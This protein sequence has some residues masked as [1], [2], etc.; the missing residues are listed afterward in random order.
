MNTLAIMCLSA[1]EDSLEQASIG[2]GAEYT[3]FFNSKLEKYGV[4]SPQELSEKDRKRFFSEVELEWDIENPLTDDGDEEDNVVLSS[5]IRYN[6]GQ[7]VLVNKG[8]D[9]ENPE[10]HTGAITKA[11]RSKYVV[12]LDSGDIVSYS[13]DDTGTGILGLVNPNEVHRMAV[14]NYK[15]ASI[16]MYPVCHIPQYEKPKNQLVYESMFGE[17]DSK[18]N[19]VLKAYPMSVFN[20]Q[21]QVQEPEAPVQEEQPSAD[22]SGNY[23]V[24]DGKT[25]DPAPVSFKDDTIEYS[26]EEEA[27]PESESEPELDEDDI[28]AEKD[29]GDEDD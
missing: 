25:P 9:L 11:G 4:S 20:E 26:E 29:G 28:A 12:A 10:F 27:E 8:A 13:A 16:V 19:R 18:P 6:P 15:A 24:G 5:V 14:P 7:R 22:E 23:K 21:E 17:D 3:D 1:V 2:M